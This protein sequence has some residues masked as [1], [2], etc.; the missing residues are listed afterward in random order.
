M[1]GIAGILNFDRKPV[2]ERVLGRM[3]SALAH[4]GPD[5]SGVWIEGP[6]GLGHRRLSIIDLSTAAAQPMIIDNGRFVLSYN[7]EVYNFKELQNELERLGHSFVSRS[8]TE[9]V[10]LALTQWGAKAIERF[11]GMFA[12]ALWDAERGELFLARDRYGIK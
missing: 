1:C 12:L 6:V 5:G 10:L 9:V 2:D 8:D 4:R 11:N 3:T 7:G